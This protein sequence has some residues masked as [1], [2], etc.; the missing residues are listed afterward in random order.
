MFGVRQLLLFTALGVGIVLPATAKTNPLPAEQPSWECHLLSL[1]VKL[2]EALRPALEALDYSL[3]HATENSAKGNF[4]EGFVPQPLV[5]QL[6][7]VIAEYEVQKLGVPSDG[8][9]KSKRLAGQ[10]KR[11][12]RNQEIEDT[13]L[14]E[15][16]R[17]QNDGETGGQAILDTYLGLL[18]ESEK[19]LA[20]FIDAKD[21]G[22]IRHK[23]YLEVVAALVF[24]R[25]PSGALTVIPKNQ[26]QYVLD[27]AKGLPDS[28]DYFTFQKNLE[29]LAQSLLTKRFRLPENFTSDVYKTLRAGAVIPTFDPGFT[30]YDDNQT[31]GL[32]LEY[33]PLN[34]HIPETLYRNFYERMKRFGQSLMALKIRVDSS[35]RYSMTDLLSS[36]AKVMKAYHAVR[37]RLS[38]HD[39]KVLDLAFASTRFQVVGF[40]IIG[41]EEIKQALTRIG[42]DS[43]GGLNTFSQL[44]LETP[45]AQAFIKN[46]LDDY[47]N[48][49]LFVHLAMELGKSI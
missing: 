49:Y 24:L 33:I 48:E 34:L 18:E 14:L 10:I 25:D 43:K 5:N 40:N 15:L 27:L 36:Y 37:G 19:L 26:F 9:T 41:E 47:L 7:Q 11:R 4:L 32:P 28:R 21:H 39:Q 20:Q 16:I 8:M 22:Y 44:Y 17:S 1:G 38:E 6:V 31:I 12:I 30:L 46:E 29:Y 35:S 2:P 45:E 23:E 42:I 13:T 3:T